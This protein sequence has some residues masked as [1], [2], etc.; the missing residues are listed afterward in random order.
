MKYIPA[1]LLLMPLSVIADTMDVNLSW[2]HA[3]EREDNSELIIDD[4]QGHKIYYG[5]ESDNYV[6]S[7]LVHGN[8]VLAYTINDLPYVDHY[9]VITTIDT[10]GRESVYST[11]LVVQA[12]KYK[13]PSKPKNA[14]LTDKYGPVC[15]VQFEH[16]YTYTDGSSMSPALIKVK[17]YHDDGTAIKG[18]ATYAEDYIY[19]NSGSHLCY[20]CEELYLMAQDVH[21]PKEDPN[22]HSDKRYLN[23]D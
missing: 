11:E 8:K 9:F 5:T 4:I 16:D 2:Q 6:N 13:K 23:C 14:R 17:L 22:R 15:R 12:S 21:V 7:V 19:F 18:H 10:D 20:K 3:T 1:I